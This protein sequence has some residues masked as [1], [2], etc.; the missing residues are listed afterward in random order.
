MKWATSHSIACILLILPAAAVTA[1]EAEA[2]ST[3]AAEAPSTRP[4]AQPG[5]VL[6]PEA[7]EAEPQPATQPGRVRAGK[8]YA[9][10]PNPENGYV[11]DQA[12]LLT[13]DEKA[14]LNDY[15]YNTER[16]TGV[17][18]VVVTIGSIK[19]YPGTANGS[20]EDFAR[21]LFDAYGVGNLPKNDGVLLLVAWRDREC[22]IKLGTH[23]GGGR[24]SDARRIMDGEILPR[25]LKGD[26]AGGINDGTLAIIREFAGL[27]IGLPWAQIG[28]GLGVL[29]LIPVCVSL[30]R[31]GK[32]GWGWVVAGIVIVLVVLIFKTAGKVLEKAPPSY[33]SGGFGGGFGGG[34]SGGGGATGRW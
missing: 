18:V 9:P 6:V 1:Q 2:P 19:D 5:Q 13:A 30:F 8:S 28:M 15:C 34:S 26:Y 12:G 22:R 23:Y 24:D 7:A 10:Y 27:R 20:I 33:R 11:T 29:A 16:R 31:R 3:Q 17:E 21:G 4:A 25:F 14:R 32:R